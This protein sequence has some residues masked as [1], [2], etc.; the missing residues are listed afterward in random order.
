[1]TQVSHWLAAVS[2]LIAGV[3]ALGMTFGAEAAQP[4]GPGGR[5]I[6]SRPAMRFPAVPGYYSL[7]IKHIRDQQFV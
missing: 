2:V 1:M 7:Q 3:V 4:E 5:T 6:M